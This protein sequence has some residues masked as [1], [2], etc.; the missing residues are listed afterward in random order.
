MPRLGT[1]DA[2]KALIPIPPYEEQ[3]RIVESVYKYTVIVERIQSEQGSLVE[4]VSN[5]KSVILELAIHG[6][7]VPQDPSDEPA[8]ELLKRINPAFKA[9]DNLHY[10]EYLPEGWCVAPLSSFC[11]TINGLWK[12]NK[13]PLVNVGVIRNANFTKDFGLDYS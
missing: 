9:S 13:E 6:K 8:I 5:C 2:I 10:E 1:A 4:Y 7:L 3:R 12:G 11:T